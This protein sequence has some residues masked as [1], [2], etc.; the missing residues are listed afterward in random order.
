MKNKEIV[1][2]TEVTLSHGQAVGLQFKWLPFL[3]KTGI[4]VFMYVSMVVEKLPEN[5]AHKLFSLVGGIA[6]AY[7]VAYIVVQCYKLFP[8]I[9]GG[10]IAMLVVFGVITFLT[11]VV[12][13]QA[14]DAAEL[15]E[16]LVMF[17]I[18]CVALIFDIRKLV[19]YI[20]Y[21]VKEKSDK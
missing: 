20:K 14:G 5:F 3:L 11:E 10:L 16:E 8:T 2:K 18:G 17:T 19:Y 6:M 7:G 21:V 1:E 9:Y 4:C 15:I 13:K 12:L